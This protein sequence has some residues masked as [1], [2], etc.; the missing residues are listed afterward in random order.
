VKVNGN[1]GDVVLDQVIGLTFEAAGNGGTILALDDEYVYPFY[2]AG[3][4]E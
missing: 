3:L 1:G 2:A 4:V